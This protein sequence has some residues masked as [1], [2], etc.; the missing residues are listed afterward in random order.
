MEIREEKRKYT[1][2]A[3][4]IGAVPSKTRSHIK[5]TVSPENHRRTREAIDQVHAV[6]KTQ[7][8]Y[9]YGSGLVSSTTAFKSEKRARDI[10]RA[11]RDAGFTDIKI[12]EDL[13]M[14]TAV[15]A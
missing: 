4:A 2:E 1:V 8:L 11:M 7:G 6:T 10:A 13:H 3:P 9:A 15:N 12:V 14:V 5:Y